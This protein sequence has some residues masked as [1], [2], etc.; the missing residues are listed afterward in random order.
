MA[1]NF[2]RVNVSISA[3]T[4]AL[5]AG[6]SDASK[7]LNNFRNATTT[8]GSSM[9]ALNAAAGESAGMFSDIPGL[10]GS[11]AASLLGV[12]RGAS[13]AA[14]GIR[15]LS[16]AVKTL[17]VPLG[18]VAAV[19][20][21]F[22]W[23]ADAARAAEEL[24]NL[25]Q[26]TGIAVADLQT[27]TQVANELGV[28]QQQMTGALRRTG[29]M[30]GELAQGTP[31]AVKAFASL[32]LTM[33]DLAG[34]ST[35]EQFALISEKIASLPPAMQA[36]AAVDIFGKSGQSMLNFIRGA[37]EATAEMK[38]LQQQ[39]GVTLT[40]EQTAAIEAMGDA[41]GRL[42]MPLQGFINQFMAELAP[43]ITAV[44][45]LIVDFF[46]KNTAGWSIAK[47]LADG[48]VQ[49]IRFVVAAM[50]LLTGI[51]QVFQAL[52]SQIGQMF[53]EV[54]SLIL[55]GVTNVM[56]SMASLA[57]AAGFTGLADSLAQGGAGAA[58]M[59]Q[60]AAEMGEMYGQA[61][62]DTF[63]SAVE[64]IGNPFGAFDAAFAQ[65]QADAQEAGARRS[66][67]A[68]GETIAASISASTKELNAVVV[69]SSEGEA[70][71]N[72]IMRGADPRLE[73]SKKD[74]K[75]TADATERAA[76][77]IEDLAANMQGGGFGQAQ[78]AMA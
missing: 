59:Q 70:L 5:T 28:S 25:S 40:D 39:L 1:N 52:G 57:E 27:M 13:T 62:A 47:T 18:V 48:L 64:N 56:E 36:A 69:G 33:N 41:L 31:S 6:L 75:R 42:S 10:F 32:G 51:F 8:T 20:A 22:R 65:A 16:V 7:Q 11:F 53:S 30:V 45:T 4:G 72:S 54:F 58:Q 34:L 3:S 23:M 61:A 2:G 14:I 71:R 17:L 73:D 68:A 26:E 21:P 67:A 66:A 15:L 74:A 24:H 46:A 49:S 44:S 9:S 38:R 43:A 63:A 78:I 50:T 77:G 55:S 19:T 29:R 12:S 37:G 35:A 60:G 76:D